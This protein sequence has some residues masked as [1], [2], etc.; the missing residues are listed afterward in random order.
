MQDTK[1]WSFQPLG[2]FQAFKCPKVTEFWTG[3]NNRQ[4]F[5]FDEMI[6]KTLFLLCNAQVT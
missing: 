3:I 1:K 6:I 4:E 5:V 2:K